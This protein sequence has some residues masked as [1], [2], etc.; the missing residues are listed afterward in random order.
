MLSLEMPFHLYRL[1]FTF[2]RFRFQMMTRVLWRCGRIWATYWQCLEMWSRKN[3][4]VLVGVVDR[5]FRSYQLLRK[6]Y[7]TYTM[8]WQRTLSLV[9][10]SPTSCRAFSSAVSLNMTI[11][12]HLSVFSAPICWLTLLS[13]IF[14]VRKI[15]QIVEVGKLKCWKCNTT[16]YHV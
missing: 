13:K 7:G 2:H 3:I 15:V 6:P 9:I 8:I 14:S 11:L 4:N 1:Q 10:R 16:G 12:K 5:H